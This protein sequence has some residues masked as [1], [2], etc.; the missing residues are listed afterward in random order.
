MA[1][2]VENGTGMSNA[3]SYVSVADADAYHVAHT[4]STT[5]AAASNTAKEI[6]LRRATSYVDEK[7]ADQWK[8]SRMAFSQALRWPRVGALDL[9]GLLI[10]TAPIPVRLR[11]AV[12]EIAAEIIDG[13]DPDPTETNEGATTSESISVG[14]ISISESFSGSSSQ[15]PKFTKAARMVADLIEPAGMRSRA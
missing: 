14:P 11:N 15:Q 13:T 3:E 6:A 2:V 10:P 7:W 9:D 5:W 4:G 8:G 1:L 12:A